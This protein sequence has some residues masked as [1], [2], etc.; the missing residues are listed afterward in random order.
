MKGALDIHRELLAR[1]VPHEIVRLPRPVLNAVELPDV[2]DMPAARC[3]AVTLFDSGTGLVATVAPA[4]T[5]PTLHAVRTAVGRRTLVPA[6]AFRVNAVTDYAASLVAP[7]LLPPS[8]PVL[9]DAS[10]ASAGIVYTPTGDSGTALGISASD[11]LDVSG[12]AVGDLSVLDPAVWP[13]F[14]RSGGRPA[15][16]QPAVRRPSLSLPRTTE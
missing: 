10:V 11:L 2:L 15:A 8:V 1:D 13:E 12:A 7:L 16:G 4:G 3:L 6:S 14:A 9:A 5:V